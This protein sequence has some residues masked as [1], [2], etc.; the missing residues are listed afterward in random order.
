MEVLF[1]AYEGPERWPK[2]WTE[3]CECA[4]G[5]RDCTGLKWSVVVGSAVICGLHCTI[6]FCIAIMRWQRRAMRVESLPSADRPDCQLAIA[7]SMNPVWTNLSRKSLRSANSV[8]R[9][10]ND[11]SRLTSPVSTAINTFLRCSKSLL[12][13]W[14]ALPKSSIVS[15]SVLKIQKRDRDSS[16]ETNIRALT[17]Q[18]N[19][20]HTNTRT[21]WAL[22]A[23]EV[24][25]SLATHWSLIAYPAHWARLFNSVWTRLCL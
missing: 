7:Q 19:A 11:L 18:T 10:P 8:S 23:H 22:D 17:T 9:M 6:M 16:H 25:W 4:I 5:D 1:L 24:H 20:K 14:R 12:I 13:R 15:L 3:E 21:L 2:V